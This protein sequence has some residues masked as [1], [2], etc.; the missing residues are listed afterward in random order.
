MSTMVQRTLSILKPDA[1][2]RNLTGAINAMIEKSGLRIVAQRRQK[3]TLDQAKA[4]YA[5]HKDRF[6][7]DDL[8]AYISSGPVI[9]QVLEGVNAIDAYRQL[10]GATDPKNAEEGTIRKAFGLSIDFNSVHG[11]D[12]METAEKEIEFFFKPEEIFS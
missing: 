11:S 7:F 4:F 5:V 3:L 9:V 2:D 6:F 1:T 12:L 8:C 10:M